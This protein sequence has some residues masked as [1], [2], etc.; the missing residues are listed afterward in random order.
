MIMNTLASMTLGLVLNMIVGRP[1]MFASLENLIL[2]VAKKMKGGLENRYQETSE[3]QIM[4]GGV[5]VFFMLL[6]F[7]GIPLLLII[8][9]YLFVPVIGILLEAFFFW[10][11]INIKNTR[12]NAYGVMR[13]AKAG[14]LEL[15][16][17]KLSRMTG[18]DC[19]NMDMDRVIKTTVEKVSDRCVNGGFSPIF[20]MT[21][22]G[23]FGAMFYKT[24]CLLNGEVVR[25]KEDY[26]DFGKG[27]KKLWNILGYLPSRIGVWLLMLDVKVLSLD[28]NNAKRVF[29]RDHTHAN[30]QFLGQ[31]RAVI[32]GALG[33][34]LNTEEYY[35]G[36]IMRKRTIGVSVKE[37]EPNDIY[38]ANQ[39]FY[40]SVFG[41]YLL[42]A[43]IRLILFFIF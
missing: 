40:G 30:P 42:F 27:V 14:N 7:A 5:L 39:L 43:V 41:F 28:K 19:S 33:I 38:W 1:S 35:D 3:A 20:Y 17:K 11:S 22:F 2:N 25:N 16:Q 10:F 12:T 32:A 37:C 8:L 31:A 24:V 21:I 29:N 9:A 4:A 34:Q 15:A 23:G 18:L 13:C 36:T 6:I 26:I